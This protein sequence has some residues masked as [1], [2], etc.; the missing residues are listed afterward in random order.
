MGTCGKGIK[1]LENN[2]TFQDKMKNVLCNI[3]Y[4]NAFY[5]IGFFCK[6][7]LPNKPYLLTVLITNYNILGDD[8]INKRGK[9]NI[10]S[11]INNNNSKTISIDESRLIY[12]NKNIYDISIIEIKD[13]DGFDFIKFLEIDDEIFKDNLDTNFKNKEIYIINNINSQVVNYYKSE[14]NNI[15]S[16]NHNLEYLSKKEV[17]LLGTPIVNC[18]NYKVIGIHKSNQ[19]INNKPLGTLIK[20]PIND[21]NDIIKQLNK[22]KF[23]SAKAKKN[24]SKYILHNSKNFIFNYTINEKIGKRLVKEIIDTQFVDGYEIYGLIDN[25]IIGILEGPP[26]TIYENGYF[27]FNII[28]SDNYPFKP[29]DFYFTTK[30]FHP[31]I[32][33]ENGYVN[34]DKL[35]DKWKPE[36]SLKNIIISIQF[37]LKD[38]NIDDFENEEAVNL[39]RKNK[40]EYENTVRHY[41]SNYANNSNIN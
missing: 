2:D 14:I 8:I 13:K 39:F 29:P 37:L 34:V 21:F 41:I 19:D 35:K 20:G 17:G 23:D 36:L 26:E 9:I 16:D 7:S 4:N 11:L 12:V 33:K 24:I 27:K 30:I 1:T 3:N 25:K 15:N 22:K 38:P 6:I 10:S 5:G 32:N 18:N 28:Y 40:K 31:N